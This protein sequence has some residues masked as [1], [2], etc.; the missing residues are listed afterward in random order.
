MSADQTLSPADPP[1][2]EETRPRPP[3]AFSWSKWGDEGKI[4]R[5]I[6]TCWEGR[7]R[8]KRKCEEP[9]RMGRGEGWDTALCVEPEC[10]HSPFLRG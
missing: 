8:R 10:S 3:L 5:G 4:V 9:G 2:R 7:R 6:K 1:Q